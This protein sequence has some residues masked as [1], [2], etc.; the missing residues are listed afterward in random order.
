MSKIIALTV[1]L[2]SGITKSYVTKENERTSG[3]L[4]EKILSVGSE[5][6]NG[7]H[8]EF[9]MLDENGNSLYH[10]EN[11][12]VIVEYERMESID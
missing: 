1:V 12:P 5:F 3:M 2:G 11:C 8:S 9:H 10:I 4:V 7:I 6:E